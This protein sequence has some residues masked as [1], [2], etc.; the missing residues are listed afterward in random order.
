MSFR[1]TLVASSLAALLGV[2][3]LLSAPAAQATSNTGAVWALLAYPD[4]LSDNAA[5]DSDG[6]FCSLCHLTEAGAGYNPYGNAMRPYISLGSTQAEIL[7]AFQAIEGLNSDADPGGFT[8]IAE[9]N[10]HTQPGWTEGDAVPN[11]LLDNLLDP[12]AAVADIAVDPVVLDFGSV[13]L[14]A[15]EQAEI[16]I[17]NEGS[18]D[19]TVTSLTLTNDT[20]FAMGTMS[21]TPPIV[22]AAG[23]S[24]NIGV[25]YTPDDTNPDNGSLLIGSDDPDEPEV[26]VA[27]SGTGFVTDLA[28]LPVVDPTK[29]AFG[30]VLVNNTLQLPVTLTNY[31]VGTCNV[32]LRVP[33]CVDSEFVLTSATPVALG[34]GESTIVTVAFTPINVG[35]NQC[36]LE[37]NT[38]S[39]DVTVP[40]SGEGV[41][42][43][44]TDL[45][46]VE[47]TA[48]AAVSLT[49][50]TNLVVPL[51]IIIINN[52]TEY[53][54]GTLTVTGKQNG[55]EFVHQVV[56]VSDLPGDTKSKK[57]KLQYYIPTEVGEIAWTATLQDGDPDEDVATAV[58]LVKK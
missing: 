57:I 21:P 47:F 2:G 26:S 5:S 31:G 28:C 55:V 58:T 17:S 41:L 34:A 7:A 1:K 22:I 4:S 30:Q 25:F 12:V 52:G 32:R 48:R 39:T 56:K 36:R 40:M 19:L 3:A 37:V 8:N 23:K 24:E 50:S 13:V 51:S 18:A 29:L 42:T 6:Y 44:P 10:A 38:Q 35:E 27:L 43:L 45:D 53:G 16:T 46:I 15:S 33:R 20:V 54:A 49:R 14:G 9:I 11:P